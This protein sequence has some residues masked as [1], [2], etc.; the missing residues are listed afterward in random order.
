MKKVT[1][2]VLAMAL[3]MLGALAVPV[4]AVSPKSLPALLTIKTSGV[5]NTVPEKTW[6]TEGGII[7]ERGIVRT[8]AYD[9]VNKYV[10]LKIGDVTYVGT[11]HA[12]VDTMKNTEI[13]MFINHYHKWLITFPVQAGVTVESSFEGT[14]IWVSEPLPGATPPF[15]IEGH[16]TLQGSGFFEG[17]TLK[18]ATEFPPSPTWNGYLIP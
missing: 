2:V 6:T 15:S 3:L 1:V 8:V 12:V 17:Q 16:A 4:M 11:I 18:I 13:G 14:N 7:Q 5:Q 9:P 10:Q